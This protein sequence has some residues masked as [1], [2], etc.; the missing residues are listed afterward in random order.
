[1][2]NKPI[3]RINLEVEQGSSWEDY[4]AADANQRSPRADER[5]RE[6]D[7]SSPERQL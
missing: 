7:D 4:R 5:G 6:M 3:G 2:L 1:M